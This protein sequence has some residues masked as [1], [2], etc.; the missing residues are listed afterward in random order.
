VESKWLRVTCSFVI[1]NLSYIRPADSPS[2]SPRF[3]ESR[4]RRMLP[5]PPL[6]PQSSQL[7]H[8]G[9]KAPSPWFQMTDLTLV[10]S[11]S[12]YS[13]SSRPIPLCLKPPK[14]TFECNSLGKEK[15]NSGI[16]LRLSYS[17]VLVH[18]DLKTQVSRARISCGPPDAPSPN[19]SPM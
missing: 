2:D 10:Y 16:R 8:S 18:P 3:G 15:K 19:R 17:P 11:E 9:Q 1:P 12:A 7:A 14:G 4:P 13:P 6:P 5:P